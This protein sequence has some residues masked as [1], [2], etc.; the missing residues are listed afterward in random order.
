MAVAF[1]C[2]L[3]TATS[4]TWAQA[5]CSKRLIVF[6]DVS[7]SM[8]PERQTR[9]S[10]YGQAV[11]ALVKLIQSRGFLA[12]G[13]ALYLAPFGDRVFPTTTASGAEEIRRRLSEVTR[14]QKVSRTDF[15]SVF[16]TVLDLLEKPDRAFNRTVVIL[17]SDFLQDAVGSRTFEPAAAEEQ[18]SSFWPQYRSRLAEV[19]AEPDTAL[20]L[21]VAPVSLSYGLEARS[22]QA[23]TVAKLKEVRNSAFQV[24][25]GAGADPVAVAQELRRSFSIP[26]RVTVKTLGA[27][28]LEVE[29]S[30]QSCLSQQVRRLLVRCQ[31]RPQQDA[32]SV[33]VPSAL[34]GPVGSKEASQ[35]IEVNVS[36]LGCDD[37]LYQVAA[38][39]DDATSEPA[40]FNLE[41]R[42]QYRPLEIAL[43]PG[44]LP[45]TTMASLRLQLGG[46]LVTEREFQLSIKSDSFPAGITTFL[47]PK[48]LPDPK[49]QDITST[50][51][52]RLLLDDRQA[53]PERGALVKVEVGSAEALAQEQLT[54]R[55]DNLAIGIDWMG[56]LIS[57][58]LGALLWSQRSEIVKVDASWRLLLIPLLPPA[59]E[60]VFRSCRMSLLEP[61]L[62]PGLVTTVY[63]IIVA[64][65]G[66][67]AL[68]WHR[69]IVQ[70]PVVEEAENFDEVSAELTAKNL[71]IARNLAILVIVAIAFLL[72]TSPWPLMEQAPILGGR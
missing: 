4:G 19:F 57:M 14:N 43:R 6:L 53:L 25:I 47:I 40:Q 24:P 44:R 66:L 7:G 39:T 59:S 2:L 27:N 10:A 9:S 20:V 5:Q 1:L 72:A 12:E 42:L 8:D 28:Q 29:I 54:V 70:A 64:G 62:G 26:P 11:D 63:L 71:R 58:L 18:W 52:Y 36:S 69:T 22:F 23:D 68:I 65:A 38:G 30:N 15:E 33:S 45:F 13:D 17:A 31:N 46:Y 41:T 67:F 55:S 3:L 37:S 50:S 34:L 49:K 61:T 56:F 60:I 16:V 48:S 35:R 32:L 21:L 51:G